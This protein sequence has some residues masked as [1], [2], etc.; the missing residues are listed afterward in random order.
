MKPRL[1]QTANVKQLV[2]LAGGR[3]S[4]L[5]SETKQVPKP[6]VQL[7]DGSCM[8]SLLLDKYVKLFPKILILAGYRAGQIIDFVSQKYFNSE[9]KIKVLLEPAPMGTSGALVY[10][11]D[12]LEEQFMLVNGDTWL[13]INPAEISN[14]RENI[15]GKVFLTS[16][17]KAGRYG[18]VSMDRNNFVIAFN[19]KSTRA[20]HRKNLINTGHYIF[21]KQIVDYI[22]YYPASLEYDTMPGHIEHRQIKGHRIANK[23]I[24]IGI[25]ETLEFARNNPEFFQNDLY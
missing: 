25:P 10:H 17:D 4:R 20:N 1:N 14:S 22:E 15:I 8:L 23:F 5:M 9:G 18:S 2:I 7:F 16:I 19:E 21:K 3:G 24:D 12:H 6:L 13:N 11:Q